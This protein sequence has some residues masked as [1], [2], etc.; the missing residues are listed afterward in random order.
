MSIRS[1]AEL[2]LAG[3]RA[4][5]RVDFN[6]PIRD[7]VIQDDTRIRAA[8]PTLRRVLDVGGALVVA[9]HLGRPK[10]APDPAFSLAPVAERLSELAGVPVELAPE[11]VGSSVEEQARNLQPGQLLLLENIR[12]H[13]GET[14]NDPELSRQLAALA[15][16]YVNDAFG[17]CHRAHASTAGMAIHFAPE[18]KAAGYLLLREIQAFQRVLDNPERPLVAILGGAKVSDKIGII[19]NLLDRADRL[20][21]GGG[22][23]YTFLASRGTPV[24]DSLLE[25]D[26]IDLAREIWEAAKAKGVDFLLPVDHVVGQEVSEDAAAR[27]SEGQGVP[28]GWKALDIGPRTRETF[29]HA[30]GDARTVVWNGPMGVFE[31]APFAAG[32]LALARAVADCPGFTVVGGGDSVSAITKSGL[33]DRIGHISTGGGAS[34][35]LLE[36]KTLPGIAALDG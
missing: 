11:V 20:L 28:D 29:A 25:A 21:I 10:G 30:L 7:G 5:V 14:E 35:E 12:F 1:V 18:Q 26:K 23:A 17:T 27:V 9:T 6:V 3:K 32:T 22:M 13:P 16:V 34:L 36:G 24:G 2:D 15:D 33:A 19:K 8:L 4:F 31:V